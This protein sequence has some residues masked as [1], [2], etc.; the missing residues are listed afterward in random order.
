MNSRTNFAASLTILSALAAAC[1]GDEAFTDG[2]TIEYSTPIRDTLAAELLTTSTAIG[3]PIGIVPTGRRLWVQDFAGDPQLHVVDAATGEVLSSLG[4]RG[5]G[6]GEFGQSVW[7]MQVLPPDTMALWT[8]DIDGQ[9]VIRVE[10]GKEPSSWR[11]VPLVG[12]P[13][14]WRLAWLDLNAIVGVHGHSNEAERFSFFDSTG[15]RTGTVP[16]KLLGGE[17]VSLAEKMQATLTG[18]GLC[19]HPGGEAFV[20][21]YF[22]FGRIEL[23]D[24]EAT[25]SA[26][27]EV[28]FPSE[29][30]F[31]RRDGGDLRFRAYRYHYMDCAPADS[32]FYMLFVGRPYDSGVAVESASHV[33]IFDWEGSLEKVLY[34][35]TPMSAIG[36][37]EE[38]GWLYG[39]G[40]SSV[41]GEPGIF[42]FRLPGG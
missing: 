24:R 21:Y 15:A 42:R 31:M 28:P 8:F 6:A 23:F 38:A 39:V 17:E 25:D 22:A 20:Q 9:R 1:G 4:R 11:T 33:H 2:L 41:E 40:T 34:L 19:A 3:I 29:P 12:S 32:R 5:E 30:I 35:D 14:V 18:F 7:G 16:G 13:S 36:V 26:L 37:D 10:L 27:A